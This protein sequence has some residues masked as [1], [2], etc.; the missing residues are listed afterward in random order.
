MSDNKIYDTI[1]DNTKFERVL[2]SFVESTETM[3]ETVEF[4]NQDGVPTIALY[5]RRNGEIV[6][7]FTLSPE[8][9]FNLMV[10]GNGIISKEGTSFNK[11]LKS[12]NDDSKSIE[13]TQYKLD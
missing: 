12:F 2:S 10:M 3:I 11:K 4:I 7:N 6:L 9:F 8:G 13:I 5:F 1:D